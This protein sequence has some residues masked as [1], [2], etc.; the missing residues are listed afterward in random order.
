MPRVEDKLDAGVLVSE[1]E[2][3]EIFDT[4]RENNLVVHLTNKLPLSPF[5]EFTG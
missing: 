4:K 1:T 5:D 3:V 2:T